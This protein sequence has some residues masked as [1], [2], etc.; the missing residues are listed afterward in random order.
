MKKH[1]THKTYNYQLTLAMRLAMWVVLGLASPS[2]FTNNIS[3]DM[4]KYH[5]IPPS[6]HAHTTEST[7]Q[8]TPSYKQEQ[9]H[10]YNPAFA[11]HIAKYPTLYQVHGGLLIDN[12]AWL[13][14]D[15]T[16]KTA[17]I[18]QENAH[19]AHRLDQTLIN[20]ISQEILA[21][22]VYKAT[23]EIWKER[24]VFFK[25]DNAKFPKIFIKTRK[26]SDSQSNNQTSD[27]WV[28]LL[29]TYAKKQTLG[30]NT[31]Q[32]GT[33]RTAPS[34]TWFATSY[35]VRG[36]ENYAIDV[37]DA[38]GQV[39][40]TL[41]NTNGQMVWL[42]D[43][44]LAYVN[45]RQSQVLVHK[46]G[47]PQSDDIAIYH[48]TNKRLAM[49]LGGT[50]SKQMI[51]L[52][53]GNLT[54]AQTLLATAN[55]LIVGDKFMPMGKIQ[56]GEEYYWEHYND[57]FYLK[58]TNKNQNALYA[59]SKDELI[60]WQTKQKLPKP[61]FVPRPGAVLESFAFVGGHLIVKVRQEGVSKIFYAKLD[62][63]HFD[64]LYHTTYK[65]GDIQQIA[66]LYYV[67]HQVWRSVT[68]DD[69]NYMVWVK[70]SGFDE[71]TH[72]NPAV[73][74]L[75]YTSPVTPT[76][77]RYYD[78]TKHRFIG[79]TPTASHAYQTK[80]LYAN[81]KDGTQL[82]IT[83]VYK[84]GMEPTKDTPLLVYG[85]GAYGFSLDPVYGGGYLSLLDRGFVYAIAHIRGGG[86][87]GRE[88]HDNGRLDKK[89][90]SFDDFVAITKAL[91]KK[92][93]GSPA[94]TFAMGESAGGLV[95]ANVC[96][97]Q[98]KLYKA[99]VM[100]V[101]FLDVLANYHQ[102]KT[103]DDDQIAEW[104]DP[105]NPIDYQTIARYNPYTNIVAKQYPNM[106]IIANR[107]DSRV[108]FVDSLKFIAKL[109]AYQTSSQSKYLITIKDGGH[110]G[111]G[112]NSRA[113]N[114]ALAYAFILGELP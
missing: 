52:T 89:Q 19:T 73:L 27:D 25:Q 44:H 21:R 55:D 101:P 46:L 107:N 95:V 28:L 71:A 94:S 62:D 20:T 84:K 91:H 59:L 66:G 67:G 76:T 5:A 72:A 45:H 37:M 87:L 26:Q 69:D 23:D 9:A 49:S 36:D 64:K 41:T 98:P 83:L 29:D 74:R 88:W 22:S 24:G 111:T 48:K 78:L 13:Y 12:Y 70:A 1:S 82:P 79:T 16:E 32:L 14:G 2:A 58:H 7:A 39:L 31:Y 6:L 43:E 108:N 106:F 57:R 56:E 96:T 47:T 103:D 81:G 40:E 51:S 110:R 80:R 8:H 112:Q 18:E 50:S 86:E 97:W 38:T 114:N 3:G 99:C 61:I 33:I 17:L 105:N 77:V 15:S 68:F 30:V 35:D 4:N 65:E 75:G 104:G 92:G 90:N 53:L 34:T 54:T 85:Y 109:R 10:A 11:I 63:L 42:D 113:E 102:G 93:Y 60:D 100:Q